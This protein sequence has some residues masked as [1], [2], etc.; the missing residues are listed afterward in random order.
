MLL[1]WLG[2]VRPAAAQPVCAN[3][4][5][6]DTITYNNFAGTSTSTATCSD[7]FKCE[8]AKSTGPVI[9]LVNP[10][11]DPKT[12]P[13]TIR[14][15]VPF[16]FPG[17]KQN[18]A[19]AGGSFGAP[20]PKAYWFLGGTPP[21]SCAPRFNADC[22]QI[23]IC[24]I[25][26][27]QYTGD[28]GETAMTVGGVSCS[29]LTDP[30]LTTFSISVFSCESRFSCPKRLDLSNIELT[31]G[32]VAQALGCPVPRKHECDDCKACKIAGHGGGSP[33]GKGGTANPA[34][35]G[36]GAMLRYAA[37]GA[38]GPGFAG[39][40]AWNTILGRY[41]SHDYAQR[42]VLDP[43]TNND[44]HVWLIT[45]AATFREFTNL[46]G[47]IYQ[48]ASP[49][50]EYGKLHRTA[51]G[52]ELH[53][54]DGTVHTFDGSGLWTQTVDRNGNAKVGTYTAGKLSSVAFPDGRNEAFTYNGA[55][56]LSTITEIGVGAA[57]SRTWTYTWTG[58][59]LTRIDRPDG[60]AW[61]FFYTDASNPGWMTRMELVGTD[62]SRRVDAAWQYDSKG[63]TIKLWRGDA[64][65][66]GTNAVE[67]WSFSFDNPTQ[68]ATATVTDPLGTVATFTIGRDPR[69]DKPRV[70]ALAGDCPSCGT[71][72]Q[73]TFFYDD[74]SNPMRPTRVVD[75]RG[76]TTAFTYNAN[77]LAT[78]RTEAMGTPLERTTTWEYNGP[79][80]SLVTR[81]EVP[82]TSGSGVRATAYAY[83]GQGNL[84]GQTISGVEAGSAF[85]YTTTTA[86][87]GAGRPVSV[88]PPGYTTQDVTSFTYDPTRGDLIPLTQTEPVV[89]DT[90]FSYDAFNR[91][92]SATD[93]N[94]VVTE[95]S[96]D[97]LNRVLTVIQ[98][99]AIT[100]E[101]LTATNVYNVFGDLFRTVLPRGNV[102]EYGYDAA[103]RLVAID[104]KPN[105]ATPGERT[106]YTLDGAGNHTREEMQRWNGSAWVT[107]SSTDYVYSTRCHLDKVIHPDGTATEFAYDCEGKP[108]RIWDANHPS[109]NQ[110]NPASQVYAY[111][112]L[113]RLITVTEP[114]GGSG[115]GTAVTHYAYDVQDHQIQ[116]TDP[117]GTVTSS[118]F[119]DHDLL[120]REE[121]EVSGVN[122]Y[123]YN[124]HGTQV[125]QT[126]AR[127]VTVS[128]AFDARD[129]VTSDDY[130]DNV[131]DTSYTY[132]D[133]AV[134]FSKGRL[135]AITRGG[136]SVAY[137]YDR[138]GRMLQ[139]GGLAYTWDKNGNRQTVAYPGGVKASYTFD[140][141]DRQAT[142]SMQDGTGPVQTLVGASTYASFGPLSGVTLGNGLSESRAYNA[143]YFPTGI[144]V[145]GR[146]DW[147]YTTDAQGNVTVVTDNLNT[148]GSRAFAYQDT[149][150][151]LTQGNGPWGARS[152]TYDKTGNRLSETR[153][154]V[155]DAYIYALN[156]AGGSSP[157]LVQINHG[158]GGASVLAYD[159]A[160]GLLSRSAGTDK[161]L[162]SYGADQRLSQVRGDSTVSGQGFSKL[163]YDGRSFLTS[164]AFSTI[165]GGT[166]PEREASATY[167]SSGLLHHRS[168]LQRRG[169]SSPRNQPQVL[170]D[171]YVFY[172]DGRPVALYEKRLVTPLSGTPTQTTS[173]T[174][175]TTDHLGAPVLATDAAGAAVWQGGFEPFGEDWN[176]ARQAGV[177]LRL[178]GQWVDPAWDNASLDSDLSY[179][180]HRWYAPDAGRYTSPDPVFLGWISNYSYALDNPAMLTDPLGLAPVPPGVNDDKCL[181]C[182]VFAE[183]RGKGK[184]C[185]DAVAS[186]ILNR[187][188]AGF[189]GA[190]TVCEVTYSD[191]Q[192]STVTGP[193]EDRVVY[194]WCIDC[195]TDKSDPNFR[196][197]YTNF[198]R[199]F[200]RGRTRTTNATYFVTNKPY[201]VK[202]AKKWKRTPVTVPGCKSL[203]FFR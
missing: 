151:F 129:R 173:V 98:R 85:S 53:E 104:N 159:P 70:T 139:D 22:G 45:P 197:D 133:P 9:E 90:T 143:R 149:Q 67:K 166:T 146:L 124:E 161:L 117:N 20:T 160:G 29:N 190:T 10:S 145:P 121:S 175:L 1:S 180:V 31:P 170:S 57:A 49:S 147:I 114:W 164:S 167:D 134:P 125:S 78:S 80:P 52:W 200:G 107:D 137:T 113:N 93:P 36:P 144:T 66:T 76:T 74:A 155:T 2:P 201:W 171:A 97:A 199:D 174:Y 183:A 86:Y 92:A 169:P 152:W 3:A 122:T 87:N 162:L 35:S 17:N 187:R 44:T 72:P 39:S 25:F 118:V 94:G 68:P 193:A 75:G 100:A 136:Q 26:G 115:G 150:Y 105:A 54:L 81:M 82:S 19:I 140:F 88:D 99:G 148:T 77:G 56:K 62:N 27:A 191:A 176:G 203:A 42:V 71:G 84:T 177:F 55:G 73:P 185:Y 157:L 83:D 32:A 43:G 46:S 63:N 69:S 91:T 18:I 50:D 21:S 11:C 79:F 41:W 12:G 158:A 109:G 142:L 202:K 198:A 24:G 181:F 110:A 108:D 13:C 61:E 16:E 47:G 156:A 60:T 111:D 188:D 59:D 123:S 38:G 126:D 30:K 196:D 34:D 184:P 5:G 192:F 106:I 194:D 165:A 130:P 116:A 48:T 119:S 132:D 112:V 102:I 153:N 4:S 8:K 33:A 96:Y 128:H 23:S 14:L 163:A 7:T 195:F 186:V 6:W 120:T 58:N 95:T 64:S 172:F 189:R 135:T 89:G 131:L 15:R 154:G 103:G 138:F 179:N 127:G 37:G 182:T 168:S 65:F 141:A 101:D 51:S 28:F 40:A 178:P